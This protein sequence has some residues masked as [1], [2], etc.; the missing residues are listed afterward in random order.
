MPSVR[1]ARPEYS[2]GEQL[3][4]ALSGL[5]KR[6]LGGLVDRLLN[7]NKI[8]QAFRKD[9]KTTRVLDVPGG[10]AAIGKGYQ[11]AGAWQVDWEREYEYYADERKVVPTG[12]SQEVEAPMSEYTHEE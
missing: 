1:V 9:S 3:R 5:S 11:D 10:K 6:D 8:L 4:P 2:S 12:A 7:A